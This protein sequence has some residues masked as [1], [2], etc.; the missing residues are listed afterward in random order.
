MPLRPRTE[1]QEIPMT[2]TVHPTTDVLI[3]VDVQRDFCP[4]GALA[5]PQGDEVVPIINRLL[6]LTGWLTVAT[7]DWHPIDH[8]SFKA[9]GGIWPP[10]CVAGTDGAT[11]H[12]ALDAKRI[13]H[14]VSKAATPD[15]EAYSG[16]Q[17][18]DLT[19][20]LAARAARRAFV[21]GLATDYCVKATALDARRAGLEVVVI[22][23]AI[24]GVEVRPGDCA[25]AIDEMK[26]SGIVL[27][28]SGDLVR[29]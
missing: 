8:C 23:D 13:G 24:R 10:H 28:S 7:R 6:T 17:G 27:A 21:C 22:D 15:A 2:I 4:G 12:P 26:A 14:I 16:F 20:L 11:F 1:G 3:V 25:K 29:P 18:T 5:V 9:Q 19:A